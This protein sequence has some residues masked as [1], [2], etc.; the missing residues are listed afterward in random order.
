MIMTDKEHDF[1]LEHARSV[2]RAEGIE[3]TLETYDID[4][5]VAPGD[6]VVNLYVSAAGKLLTFARRSY[7]DATG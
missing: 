4:L 2:A 3:K 5:I 6:S 1:L 7:L